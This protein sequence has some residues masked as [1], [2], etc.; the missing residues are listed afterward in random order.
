MGDAVYGQCSD[1][2]LY[3][4]QD[5][6]LSRVKV[7][8]EPWDLGMGGYQVGNFPP[9]WSEWNGRYR[10]TVRR[11]WKGTDGVLPEL[12]SRLAGSSDL[13]AWDGRRPRSS[14]NLVTVHEM[15]IRDS[16]RVF[17]VN[18]HRFDEPERGIDGVVFRRR[19]IIGK[20]VWQHPCLLYTSRCV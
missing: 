20:A 11:F 8:A 4:S 10:D 17:D 15:C 1:C 7:I 9:G 12:A 2:L 18:A 5:P 16:V 19:T 13:F 14:I 6:V 3:T